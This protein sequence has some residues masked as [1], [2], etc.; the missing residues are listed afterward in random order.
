[1]NDACLEVADAACLPLDSEVADLILTSPP[2]GLDKDYGG[3]DDDALA[4]MEHLYAWLREAFR[5]T[6]ERGRLALNV[7]LDTTRGG[8]RPT[9]AEAVR[10]AL[11]AGW[12]YRSSIVWED[13]HITKTT[14]RGSVD[15]ASAPHV[16]ARVEMIALFSKGR[17]GQGRLASESDLTHE[18]WLAWT[19]GLWRIPSE[20]HAWERHPAAFPEELAR[21]LITLLSFPGDL[22]VDPFVGSGTTVVV[23]ERLGRRGR[24]FDQS[25]DY[26]ASSRRR[27]AAAREGMDVGTQ[28]ARA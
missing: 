12:T 5:V 28:E 10:E 2:Y 26:V 1:M 15:S 21:R 18:E 17:W 6:R 13:D 3:E 4:W 11:A 27:L 24:G 22:V 19:N 7:P 25:A 23:A 16:I 9:Y 8:F 20:S 14:A